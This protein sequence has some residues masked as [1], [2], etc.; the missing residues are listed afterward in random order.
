MSP[1]VG[2]DDDLDAVA[3]S[4]L[5]ED[6]LDVR[7][8]RG[9]FQGQR[10]GDL[11]VRETLG[12]QLEDFPFARGELGETWVGFAAQDRVYGDPLDQ[13]PRDRG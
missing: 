5:G 11:G 1:L 4:E 7:L 2:H 6:A 12:E 8:D 9:A 3:R 13:A 10:F